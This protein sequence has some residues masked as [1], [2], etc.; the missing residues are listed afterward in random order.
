VLIRNA[1]IWTGRVDGEEVV[2]GDL[3][4]DRGLIKAIGHVRRSDLSVYGDKLK[5]YD[6][7]GSWVTPGVVDMHSHLGVYSAPALSGA[8]D[9]NSRH[10]PILPWMR[11]LDGL[12]T[13][14]DAYRLSV[15][16]GTTTAL[17]LPGSANSI[18][19][20]AFPIKLRPTAARSASA[21]LLEPPHTINGTALPAGHPPRWRHMKHACGEN[22]SRVYGNTRMDNIWAMRQGYEKARQIKNAQDEYC[23]A[24]LDG[25]WEGLDKFP[26][27]LQWESMV[28]ILRGKVKIHN[29]CY[30]TVDLNSMILM[31]QGKTFLHPVRGSHSQLNQSSASQL[32]HSIIPMRPT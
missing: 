5:E 24:A 30:E 31:T 8:S 21:M 16:G 14:D 22:P 15:S 28:D 3:L 25:R 11:S 18:G 17:V 10:G 7:Q 9:G 13:H 12:N 27:D 26:E 6:A 2:K 32:P 4:L 23:S 20:Q 19:G 29:H 1:T